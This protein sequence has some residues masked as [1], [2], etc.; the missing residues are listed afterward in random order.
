MLLLFLRLSAFFGA[1][2]GGFFGFALLLPP[3]ID[4]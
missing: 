1:L 2:C 4:E 3:A